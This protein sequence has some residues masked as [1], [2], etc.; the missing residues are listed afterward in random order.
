M[1]TKFLSYG[2]NDLE[3][4]K[5]IRKC[6]EK[7]AQE[8]NLDPISTLKSLESTLE[9]EGVRRWYGKLAE[10]YY[11]SNV[12][13]TFDDAENKK[14]RKNAED[15]LLYLPVIVTGA[16]PGDVIIG[17]KQAKN[18]VL[19]LSEFIPPKT[20]ELDLIRGYSDLWERFLIKLGMISFFGDM[21]KIEKEMYLDFVQS[22]AD[23]YLEDVA[24]LEVEINQFGESDFL[25]LTEENL[26]KLGSGNSFGIKE[27]VSMFPSK[28]GSLGLKGRHTLIFRR[29][30]WRIAVGHR[31]VKEWDGLVINSTSGKVLSGLTKA[32]KSET[33]YVF[34]SFAKTYKKKPKRGYI[35]VDEQEVGILSSKSHI[36]F[37]EEGME[38]V[39][40]TFG[41]SKTDRDIFKNA[42]R[43]FTSASYKS[44]LQKLVRFRP[45]KVSLEGEI[46]EVDKVFVCTFIYLMLNP[47]G[48]VP[49]IQRYV[50]GMEAAFKRLVVILFEDGFIIKDDEAKV[51]NVICAAFLAQR[52]PGWKPSDK[53]IKN[54]IKLGLKS[55]END[56]CFT[57]DFE[58]GA[59]T[60]P[61]ILSQKTKILEAVSSFMEELKTFESDL[62]MMRDICTKRYTKKEV[63]VF[64]ELRP[65]IM[66][67]EHCV[68]QHWAPE[69]CY[70][71]PKDL[72]LENKHSG[73]KPYGGLLTKLFS[74]VTGINPRRPPRKGKYMNP[75]GYKSDF[76]SRKFTIITREAE[77][78]T[79][80]AKQNT[81]EL[82]REILDEDS[83]EL[84]YV[85]DDGWIAGMVSALKIKGNPPILVT[86]HPRDLATFVAIRKPSRDMKDGTLTDKREAEAI[87][88]AKDMLTKGISLSASNPP[89]PELKKAS[90]YLE[91]EKLMV[92]YTSPHSKGE[93]KVEWDNFKKRVTYVPYVKDVELTI[94]NALVYEGKGI[95]KNADLK[96]RKILKTFKPE[97]VHRTLAVLGGFQTMI[98]FGR[99]GRDGGGTLSPI[100]VEDV[101]A[102]ELIC[103]IKLL[104]PSALHRVK[105]NALRFNVGLGPLLWHV[106][107]II[108]GEVKTL[109]SSGRG[110]ENIGEK[111]KRKLYDYQVSSLEEM[112]TNHN[113]GQKGHFIWLFVGMGKTLLTF[114]Y[115]KWLQNQNKLPKYVVYTL[116]KSAVESIMKESEMF[117]FDYVYLVPLKS[118]GDYKNI[119]KVKLGAGLEPYKINL[120]EH[121]NLKYAVDDFQPHM[122]EAIFICDEV[123]KALNDTLRTKSALTLSHLSKEFIALTGTPIIDTHTYKLIWWLQ[124]ISKFEVNEKNFWVGCNGMIARKSTTGIVIEKSEIEIELEGKELLEY[125][126]LVPPALGGRNTH[127]RYEDIRKAMELCYNVATRGMVDEVRNSLKIG[128]KCFVIAKDVTHQE[129]LR[130]LIMGVCKIKEKDIF[131]VGKN[132]TIFLTEDSVK[133]GDVHDYKVVITTIRLAEGYTAVTLNTL[134]RCPMPSAESTRTQLEGRIDRKSSK[135]K[136]IYHKMVTCGILTY[137]LKKHMEARSI[138]LALEGIAKEVGLRE[139]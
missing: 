8:H 54:S 62:T 120:I 134:I 58:Q 31:E 76:E 53:I 117:G 88:T 72:V 75:I 6:I 33:I 107:D 68:D 113:L 40:L 2:D 49:D 3:R 21:S 114:S 129:E 108:A 94:K 60:T 65:K 24:G 123:H 89:I 122:G 85:L 105:G 97:Y 78:L 115:L 110:W 127:P 42:C 103:Y 23:L 128:N 11:S 29:G 79:L 70:F 7:T 64:S 95:V 100:S 80:F 119:N 124:Q 59:K 46:L 133:R 56:S 35:V 104:Y 83:Y 136:K 66:S 131:L 135:H 137:I 26:E 81:L 39:F 47:G 16:R 15:N 102:Y 25:E 41:V 121:D 101:G 57:W 138:A 109:E 112:K 19:K 1:E 90:V 98:E 96:L 125:S 30:I 43:S 116:P 5:N 118:L 69:I 10:K 38:D 36:N 132:R 9:F 55:I 51:L 14:H 34:D 52:M 126:S 91:N 84:N 20:Q 73:S 74:E 99:I 111:H 17:A 86:L 67:L 48:F 44:L 27:V 32:E 106:R 45:L 28:P 139:N 50:T 87:S 130:E 18:A 63:D 61:F 37:S 93:K 77:K 13:G 4:Y 12:I 92:K 82:E 22:D 71:Y